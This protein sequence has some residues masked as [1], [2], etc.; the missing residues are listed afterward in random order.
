M[1]ERPPFIGFGG[2]SMTSSSR[3]AFVHYLLAF[4]TLSIVAVSSGAQQLPP[5]AA[6]M[7][8]TYGLSAFGEVEAIRYTWRDFQEL[9]MATKNRYG[10]I[11]GQ[12]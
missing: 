11:P 10:Y 2:M 3:L 5:L 8:K 1:C 6:E 12:G 9:G 4:T 7:A